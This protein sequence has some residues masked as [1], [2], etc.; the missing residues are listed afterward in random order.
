[1][2]LQH[3]ALIASLCLVTGCSSTG[4]TS[5]NKRASKIVQQVNPSHVERPSVKELA[6]S[7]SE[8]DTTSTYTGSV[9]ELSGKVIA[10][11]LT[12]D[13]LYTITIKQ[14]D[15]HIVCVFDNSIAD[16]IGG[17]RLA[18]R[19]STITVQGQCFASGL[20]SSNMFTLDGCKLVSN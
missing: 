14:D 17:G 1:M 9:V 19:G 12:E 16:Q 4:N 8:I 13:G 7:F 11:S 2:N 18:S 15:T 20:F 10:Y 5:Q 6:S 3:L